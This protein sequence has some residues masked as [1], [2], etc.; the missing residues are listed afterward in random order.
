MKVFVS[1]YTVEWA[2]C[3]AAGIVFYPHFYTWFDQGTERLFGANGLSYAALRRDF[4]VVGMPLLET[5][6]RYENPCRLGDRL[7]MSSRVDEWAGRT[8]VVKHRIVHADGRPAL[9]GFERRAWVVPDPD[10]PR[11]ARA[12]TVPAAVTARFV[13]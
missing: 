5:G 12:I 10:A 6:A 13:D 2:H 7:A 4:G 8:F 3:D 11:G 1:R 9:E